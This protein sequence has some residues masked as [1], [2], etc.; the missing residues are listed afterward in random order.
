MR[1]A[2]Q[3]EALR[4]S[5]TYLEDSMMVPGIE[6]AAGEVCQKWEKVNA[7][8]NKKITNLSLSLSYFS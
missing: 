6:G 1:V 2:D 5:S 7:K 4:V 8:E 3:S